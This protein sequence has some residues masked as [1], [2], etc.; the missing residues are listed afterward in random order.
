MNESDHLAEINVRAPRYFIM[1]YRGVC[2]HCSAPTDLFGLAL[3][4]GHETL[5][6]DDAADDA[7]AAEDVAATEAAGKAA[8][9]SAWISAHDPAFIFHIEFLNAEVAARLASVTSLFRV[10]QQESAAAPA[11]ANHCEAC[12]ACF[13]DEALFCEPGEPFFPTSEVHAAAIQLLAIDEPLEAGA[14]GYSFDPNFMH[15]MRWE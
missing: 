11:W 3:P 4:P 2:P 8:A 6:V 13:D 14:G 10:D 12:G 5:D 15:V 7:A 1:R 9:A